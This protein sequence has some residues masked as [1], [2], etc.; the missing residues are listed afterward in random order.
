[1]KNNERLQILLPKYIAAEEKK[2]NN[3]FVTE[4][5][6]EGYIYM[7]D[8][9]AVMPDA[10]DCLV[11]LP[12]HPVILMQTINTMSCSHEI[13]MD[14]LE[15]YL[16]RKKTKRQR[17]SLAE[18]EELMEQAVDLEEFE[19]AATIRNKIAKRKKK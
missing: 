5:L 1:M 7:L 4:S 12:Y 11:V 14:F 13:H 18:L 15:N 9:K 17:M 19:L 2:I 10:Q 8:C 16:V 6:A 3:E